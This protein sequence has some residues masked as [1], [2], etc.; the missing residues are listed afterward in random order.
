MET[1]K[2]LENTRLFENYVRVDS[3]VEWAQDNSK[4]VVAY[5]KNSRSAVE[6]TQLAKEIIEYANR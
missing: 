3:A 5:K 1:L 4:P 6:Y 2:E